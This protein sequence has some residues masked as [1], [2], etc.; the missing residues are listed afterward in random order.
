[1]CLAPGTLRTTAGGVVLI[2]SWTFS[3]DAP[4]HNPSWR[5]TLRKRRAPP[6]CRY[7]AY[8][9]RW[10]SVGV[11][12]TNGDAQLVAGICRSHFTLTHSRVR[13]AARPPQPRRQVRTFRAPHT[14][15][16]CL[17]AR[18]RRFHKS[19]CAAASFTIA[20]TSS[21]PGTCMAQS[22]VVSLLIVVSSRCRQFEILVADS[23]FGLFP[24]V[25]D[26]LG[27][28]ADGLNPV[29]SG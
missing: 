13:A 11:L 20:Y 12:G 17:A 21:A 8:R 27:V 15:R 28:L 3:A 29:G 24:G 10:A 4:G 5:G 22:F 26:T 1:M 9:H 6:L 18:C 19:S 14:S 16:W 25:I 23:P 7:A 2:Y